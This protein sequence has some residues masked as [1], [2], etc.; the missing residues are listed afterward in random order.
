MYHTTEATFPPGMRT[1]P[2]GRIM[3]V[4]T[5]FWTQFLLPY[6]D[7]DPL[8]RS[9]DY[10]VGLATPAW[11]AANADAYRTVIKVYQCP[12]D[13]PGFLTWS[14]SPFERFSRSNYV[15]C[16]SADGGMVEPG[17]SQEGDDSNNNPLLNPSVLSGKRALFNQNVAHPTSAVTDGLSNT[18]AFSE[19]IAGPNGSGGMRGYWW[20]HFGLQY[21]HLL[22]PNSP[23]PDRTLP[24]YCDASKTPCQPTAV[25]PCT[26]VIGARSYHATGVNVALADGAVRFMNNGVDLAVWQALG[27]INGAEV[28]P[29]GE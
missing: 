20:G 12:A 2:P 21:T 6:L 13:S 22:T 7:Q 15:A 14:G 5:K 1:T 16:Y 24:G 25:S 9:Q 3:G 18:A 29:G 10:T 28:V 26:V 11:F 27:S 23:L 4:P 19:V 8:D 17:M